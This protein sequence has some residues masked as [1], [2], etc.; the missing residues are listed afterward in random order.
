MVSTG[1]R[2]DLKIIQLTDFTPAELDEALKK[3]GVTELFVARR[4]GEGADAHIQT[5]R[6]LL[7][8]PQAFGLYISLRRRGATSVS[9]GDFTWSDL[10]QSYTDE[11]LKKIEQVSQ[12]CEAFLRK[13]L[14][15]FAKLARQRKA[16]DFYLDVDLIDDTFPDWETKWIEPSRSVYAALKDYGFLVER[17]APGAK[18]QAGFQISDVGS[19]L[20]AF[21][22]DQEAREAIN[23]QEL[24]DEWLHE[25]EDYVPLLDA[26]L[27]WMNHLVLISEPANSWLLCLVK[28][29]LNRYYL[30]SEMLFRLMRPAILKTLLEAVNDEDNASFLQYRKAALSIRPSPETASY[31]S[32]YLKSPHPQVR[33]LAAQLAG[34]H[35]DSKL[36]PELINTLRDDE[37]DV[38]SAAYDSL[39]EIGKPAL[40]LLLDIA[41]NS[42]QPTEHRINCLIAIRGIGFRDDDVS[43]VL[44][45]CIQDG[46][47]GEPSLL[48]N[49][50]LVAARLRDA[51]QVIGAMK[52][53]SSQDSGV[54]QRA[55]KLLSEVPQ[56]LAFISLKTTLSSWSLQGDDSWEHHVTIRQL[57]ATLHKLGTI[58]ATETV[59]QFL[60]Q[61]LAESGNYHPVDA[62]HAA[63]RLNIAEGY[64]LVWENLAHQLQHSQPDNIIWHSTNALSETWHP[65]HLN[66]LHETTQRLV[67]QGIDAAKLL[68][69]TKIPT[70]KGDNLFNH[71]GITL[72]YTLAKCQVPNF[73]EQARR[74]LEVSGYPF[75]LEISD[76][77]WVVADSHAED[78][79]LYKIKQQ[80]RQD[81]REMV[82]R[83]RIIRALGTCGTEKSQES[84]LHYLRSEETIELHTPNDAIYPLI[85]RGILS[86]EML[87]E[88]VQDEQA[89]ASGRATCLIVLGM[90]DP[91]AYIELCCSLCS[92][93]EEDPTVQG[94]AARILGFAKDT[95]VAPLLNQFRGRV[96]HSFVQ[97]QATEALERLG[98]LPSSIPKAIERA[99]EDLTSTHY[100]QSKAI[101]TL[102]RH[103]KGEFIERILAL[104][105]EG[106]LNSNAREILANWV[107][108]L[109]QADTADK[110]ISINLLKRLVCDTDLPV[111]ELVGQRLVRIDKVVCEQIYQ[112]LYDS[113]DDWTR[114]CAVRTLG[115]WE[116]NETRIQAYRYDSSFVVRYFADQAYATYHKRHALD[117]L[118]TQFQAST[119]V[120]RLARYLALSEQ[121]DEQAIWKLYDVVSE[122]DPATMFIRQLTHDIHERLRKD[123][124]E[125]M[126]EEAKV[127]ENLTTI[128]F[129]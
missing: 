98:V 56:E 43:S 42:T 37:R 48:G 120:A 3:A 68:A 35:Y 54:I 5:L 110:S 29:L 20:L 85:Q 82:G 62:I 44:E 117:R 21:A 97:E 113:P 64:S 106:S 102:M 59:L 13:D 55:A 49:A 45:V 89:S 67:D 30:H 105:D 15:A 90:L 83:S 121:G 80:D 76:A 96:S 79:L 75:I 95:S 84:I 46:L 111:R 17:T 63:K 93:T 123:R 19:Y 101:H 72:L 32:H 53:L 88:L 52:G 31:I 112:E 39:C 23:Y 115:F 118:V 8:Y 66:A 10:I 124:R 24:F 69:D 57:L 28:L 60:W 92:R 50:L 1:T 26:I 47:Q 81:R 114:A 12:I 61:A 108:S 126:K 36:L 104:Y 11:N 2:D 74:L 22:L 128:W 107:I 27:A 58:E 25:A 129:D 87:V 122:H 125:A 38:H 41:G 16:R 4:P 78:A 99:L 18:L 9:M 40:A 34:S 127:L 103:P 71:D 73:T 119:G 116:D 100:A 7:V 14:I 94:Y 33:E 65:D 77:L 86:R 91:D 6:S 70:I 109:F 51:R